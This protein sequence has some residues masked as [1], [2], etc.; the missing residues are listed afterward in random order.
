MINLSLVKTQLS[1]DVYAMLFVPEYI[2]ETIL[3]VA[4][5]IA[6]WV[7]NCQIYRADEDMFISL[8]PRESQVFSVI[9][10]IH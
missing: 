8:S 3:D 9:F 6:S 1:P 10:L 4:D 7:D 2:V 5:H